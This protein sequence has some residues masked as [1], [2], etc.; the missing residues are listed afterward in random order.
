MLVAAA[1]TVLAW[2]SAFVV[3]RFAGP[4]YSPGALTLGRLVVGA[5]ALTVLMVGRRRVALS[6]REWVLVT[7]VGVAWFGVYNVALN[8]GE[9]YVDAGTAAMLIQLAPIL[10]GVLAGFLLNEGFPR[11]L[12]IGG[13]VAFAGT[14]MI[15][16]ATSTGQAS[17][18]GVLLVLLSA[19]VYS[20][21]TVAQKILLRRISGLQVT[22]L[23]CSIGM[24]ACLV[25]LPSL[26]ADARSAPMSATLG[27]V[28]LGLVPTAIAFSTW[29][30]ALARSDAGRLGATTYIVPPV[31]IALGW[32]FLGEVPAVL[33]IVGG[34]VSLVGVGI[35]RRR[36]PAPVAGPPAPEGRDDR[37]G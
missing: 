36:S 28:Y 20:V 7:L 2:A 21:A 4:F 29:A 26:V 37:V 25:Y 34:L 33:A 16:V 3:I 24:L 8:A 18:K 30:Y 35:A 15:G 19:V 14:L 13:L 10:I 11:M 5:A 31:T 17:A 12:V 6:R 22:W 27:V 32:L 23:G 9:K 1:I